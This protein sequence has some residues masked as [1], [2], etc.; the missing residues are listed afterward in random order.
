MET[1]EPFCIRDQLVTPDYLALI[2]DSDGLPDA[3][4]PL[5]V[6]DDVVIV[7]RAVCGALENLNRGIDVFGYKRGT[8]AP[9]QYDDYEELLD[10]IAKEMGGL[11]AKRDEAGTSSASHKMGAGML[12]IDESYMGKQQDQQEEYVRGLRS[13]IMAITQRMQAALGKFE[14]TEGG[15]R[16]QQQREKLLLAKI[17]AN[18]TVRD[19]QDCQ[20]LTVCAARL[21]LSC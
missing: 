12:E 18:N 10:S 1:L 15:M 19:C 14:E 13:S 7:Q 20:D 2:S 5:S 16:H 8:I 3:D 4:S 21:C 9:L 6:P 11:E 17:V